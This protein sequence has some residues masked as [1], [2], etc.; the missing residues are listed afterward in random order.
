MQIF[1]DPRSSCMIYSWGPLSGGSTARL[2]RS[3]EFRALV[4]DLSAQFDLVLVDGPRART[5]RMSCFCAVPSKW[6]CSSQC[7]RERPCPTC[8]PPYGTSRALAD[9]GSSRA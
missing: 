9:A 3:P 5:S 8:K 4:H 1:E 6:Q 2:F 7:S